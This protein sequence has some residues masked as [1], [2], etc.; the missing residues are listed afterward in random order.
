MISRGPKGSAGERKFMEERIQ[1]IIAAA[2]VASRRTAEQLI[3]EGRVRVN[4]QVVTE[5]GTKADSTRDHI[6]VDG[7][8]INP[9]QPP[10]YIMLNKPAGFVTTMSDPE[11]RPTVQDLV[12][13]VKTRVYPVGR[14]DYN[15]EGLLLLTNDG[16]FAH[17]I[18]H[19][20]HEF[21]K[22][23]L[24]KVKG[25][26]SDAQIETLEKGMFLQDGR[27]A[28]AK[29]KKVRKEEA[30]SWIEITI[31]EGRKRQVRRMFDHVGSSVIK[32]KRTRTGSLLLGDLPEGRF[33]HL[34]SDEIRAL[35]DTALKTDESGRQIKVYKPAV[36]ARRADGKTGNEGGG[37]REEERRLTTR[38]PGIPDTRSGL[39]KNQ[40]ITARTSP[41]R[42]E[43]ISRRGERGHGPGPRRTP[44]RPP[45]SGSGERRS[46]FSSTGS[47]R[48]VTSNT[49]SRL[50]MSQGVKDNNTVRKREG[51]SPREERTIGSDSRRT[52]GRP[53]VSG[54]GG[55]RTAFGSTGSGRM[56]M[57]DTRSGLR[58]NQGVR[59]NNAVRKS[60][61]S[62]RRE[63]RSTG[64]EPRRTPASTASGWGGRR[65]PFGTARPQPGTGSEKRKTSSGPRP[66]KSTYSGGRGAARRI[67]RGPGS[68]TKGPGR[69]GTRR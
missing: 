8:L 34:T 42:S 9:K 26:L 36:P 58:K 10:T 39:R 41:R 18:T 22:T 47:G 43:D 14:L 57:H 3:A 63:E 33:R 13:G 25:V 48:M 59:D 68:G 54:S 24:A 53:P 28:P 40:G 69:P 15:T 1:K 4:G 56:V 27:T 32:L 44:G 30:N 31:H 11:G 12:S 52:P 37:R 21:P 46:A 35:R 19:P 55:R 51:F 5:P 67:P 60:E 49:R 38:R 45:V 17:L 7:K 66:N 61:G 2:G 16:D 6:K 29:V 20:K 65:P 23:Y 62:S 50:R 64:P